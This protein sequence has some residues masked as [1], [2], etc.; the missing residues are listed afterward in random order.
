MA[1]RKKVKLKT[2]IFLITSFI[3]LN[4]LFFLNA[5]AQEEKTTVTGNEMKIV[6]GGDKI[7]YSGNS[8]VVRGENV[9]KAD[10][11]VRNAKNN[12]VEASGN[13][14]F[15]TFNSEKEKISGKSENAKYNIKSG[16]GQLWNGNPKITY[17]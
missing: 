4:L 11:I 7:I 12:V 6:D 9:L 10:K 8:K 15:L 16:K 1:A 17:Y 13:V 2:T 14:K 3:L 5:G